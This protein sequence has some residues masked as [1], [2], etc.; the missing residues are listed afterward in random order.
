MNLKACPPAESRGV[1][2]KHLLVSRTD[3]DEA[4]RDP[5][6]IVERNDNDEV[7]AF[8]LD[9]REVLD[10]GRQMANRTPRCEGP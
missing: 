5:P 1:I 8:R 4:G 6:S 7:N 10:V 3:G 2:P 9:L